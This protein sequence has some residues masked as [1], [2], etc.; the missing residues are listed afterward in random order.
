MALTLT[1]AAP[2]HAL[3]FKADID[4]STVPVGGQL[5]LRFILSGGGRDLPRLRAPAIDGFDTYSA[6]TSQSVAITNG[7]MEVTFTQTFILLAKREGRFTLGPFELTHEGAKLTTESFAVDVV[8]AGRAPTQAEPRSSARSRGARGASSEKDFFVRAEI[9]KSEAYVNEQ[10]TMTV[11]FY[12]RVRLSRDPE[13]APP[14]ASGFW[15]ED[16]PPVRQY[17][18]DVGGVQYLVNEVKSALF[19]TSAGEL[20]IGPATVKVLRSAADNWRLR[21][22]FQAFGQDPFALLDSGK[23]EV[24]T[25]KPLKLRVRALPPAPRPGTASGLVGQYTLSARVDKT[26]V[27]ANQ[28][29]TL[30]LTLTG[31]GNL[32]TAPEPALVLPQ[33]VRAYDSQSRVNTNKEGYR[34]RGEKI[35]EKVLIPQSP[36]R[37]VIPPATLVVFDP[38]KGDFREL[39]SDTLEVDVAPSSSPALAGH[40][41]RAV[42]RIGRDL[43]EIRK[44]ERVLAK[45]KRWFYTNAGFWVVQAL[46]IG[47]FLVAHHFGRARLRL[48][49]DAGLARSL[50]AR[51]AASKRLRDARAAAG[52][53]TSDRFFTLLGRSMADFAADKLGISRHGLS[54]DD[55]VDALRARG[56]SEELLVGFR[57]LLDRCDMGRFAPGGDDLTERNGLLTRAEDLIV[58]LEKLFRV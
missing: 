6:G 32:S 56:A 16:L 22:P 54:R 19:A 30:T 21:D 20:T 9:D 53:P 24:L 17:M 18:E 10:V 50:R 33:G 37:L 5:T 31:D 43:R 7:A 11:K 57:D 29:V 42:R 44:D 13:Y 41:E 14:T 49:S 36:G 51:A 58:E 40:G 2:L 8:A 25:S 15:V 23:P 39:R 4:R 35:V 47:L 52:A 38:R 46:P 48:E 26:R 27:E 45:P 3:Q 34:L 55:V 12:S 28:P 1:A